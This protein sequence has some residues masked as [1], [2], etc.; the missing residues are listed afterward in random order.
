LSAG[1]STTSVVTQNAMDPVDS[2]SANKTMKQVL[3]ADPQWNAI[4]NEVIYCVNGLALIEPALKQKEIYVSKS[5]NTSPEIM[6]FRAV[7]MTKLVQNGFNITF[8][9]SNAYSM[10]YEVVTNKSD[11]DTMSGDTMSVTSNSV[12]IRV[13]MIKGDKVITIHREMPASPDD[14]WQARLVHLAKNL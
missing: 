13:A 8:D 14:K 2:M 3:R 12:L 10:K 5:E 7:I 6:A 1:C 4:A 11:G 9:S